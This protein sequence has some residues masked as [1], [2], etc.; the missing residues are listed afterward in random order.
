MLGDLGFELAGAPSEPD[1]ELGHDAPGEV[2]PAPRP[3]VPDAQD[4]RSEALDV[5]LAVA[6]EGPDPVRRDDAMPARA[7]RTEDDDEAEGRPRVGVD[8]QAREP[9]EG[10]GQVDRIDRRRDGQ[11]LTG[12]G[13]VPADDRCGLRIG[14]VGEPDGWL[15]RRDLVRPAGRG[16]AG[17]DGLTPRAV[18]AG[19]DERQPSGEERLEEPG[20]ARLDRPVRDEGGEPPRRLRLGERRR[21]R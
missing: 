4:R 20:E 14:R 5:A 13:E 11:P 7:H 10:V 12:R 8:P 15:R 3:R 6:D 9:V 21:R 18:G 16:Q 2:V 19:D 1:G 17:G